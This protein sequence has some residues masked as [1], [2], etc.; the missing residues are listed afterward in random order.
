[1]P[2]KLT[3]MISDMT[4]PMGRTLGLPEAVLDAI[5]TK[6]GDGILGV[7]TTRGMSTLY[8]ASDILT[9]FAQ[10]IREDD[11]LKCEQITDITA[12]DWPERENRFD[13]VYH[14]LSYA[15][16]LRL[17][18]KIQIAENESAPS[19]SHIYKGANWPEREVYDLFGIRFKDHPDLRRILMWE[20]FDGW[21]LRKDFPMVGKTRHPKAPLDYASQLTVKLKEDD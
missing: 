14:A 17:R 13:V 1:M 6:F 9:E 5:K 16:K 21:P 20:E 11:N 8:I 12:V 18:F 2:L 15:K 4:V 10:F 7:E 3:P 19:I